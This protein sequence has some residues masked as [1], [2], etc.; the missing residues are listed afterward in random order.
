MSISTGYLPEDW[1]LAKVTPVYKNKG[2]KND[3]GSYRP[4]SVICHIAKI[5]EKAVQTQLKNYLLEHDFITNIQSAYLANH[6]TQSSLHN[7]V[8]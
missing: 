5:M 8:M 6:S 3:C 1:K 7:V 4:I 2:A